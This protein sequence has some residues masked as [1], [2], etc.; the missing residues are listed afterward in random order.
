MVKVA[1]AAQ[2]EHAHDPA[3]VMEGLNSVLSGKLQGQFVTAAYL[4]LDLEA[5]VASYSAAGHPPLL[6]YR[7]AERS[8]HDVVENGL[9]LGVMPFATYQSKALTFGAGDRFLLYTDG[10]IEADQR[11]EEF[12]AARVKQLLLRSLSAQDICRS[13]GAEISAWSQG[14]AGDDVTILAVDIA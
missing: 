2:A 11:G 8:I 6:H 3:K 14:V 1:I 10:V 9:I 7:A 13:L 12:G 4:F 5:S